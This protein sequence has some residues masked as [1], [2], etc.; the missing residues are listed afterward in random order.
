MKMGEVFQTEVKQMQ[1]T[2]PN[3]VPRIVVTDDGAMTKTQERD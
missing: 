2:L 3:L 1:K